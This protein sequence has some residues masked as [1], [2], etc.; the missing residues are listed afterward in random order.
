MPSQHRLTMGN[1]TVHRSWSPPVLAIMLLLFACFPSACTSST[2]PGQSGLSSAPTVPPPTRDQTGTG[3]VTV[4]GMAVPDVWAALSFRRDGVV[5]SILVE[6]GQRVTTGQV[7]IRLN[8]DNLKLAVAQAE[9]TLATAQAELAQL[10]APTKQVAQTGAALAT[11]QAKL[12]QLKAPTRQVAQTEAALATA[13]ARLAQLKAPPRQED[14]AV[15][16]A[17]VD[18]AKAN[19]VASQARLATTEA[20]GAA[21]EADLDASRADLTGFEAALS[22][23]Q[24]G[25]NQ[26]ELDLATLEIERAKN[27]LWAAQLTRDAVAGDPSTPE[28]RVKVAQATTGSADVAVRIAELE[29]EQLSAAPNADEVA[30]AQADVSAAKASVTGAEARLTQAQARLDEMHAE[31]DAS[32][33]S[34]EQAQ[35][36]LAYLLAGPTLEEIAVAEAGVKEAEV[37]YLLAGPTLEEIAVA[38]A[39][40][41]EAEVAYLL[42]GPTS[43]EIAVAEAEVKEAE[44]GLA[45]AQAG[46]RQAEL[47]A[48]FS[49]TVIELFVREGESVSA[50]QP[51]VVL[52]D[53]SRSHVESTNL[54]ELDVTKIEIG[55]PAE[56]TFDALPGQRLS[57]WVS[58]IGLRG[59]ATEEGTLYKV[60]IQLHEQMPEI[61]W[62]ILARVEVCP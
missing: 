19:L 54:D 21:A 22:A 57:G 16:Q 5:E 15:A 61:R 26:F 11:A 42:A 14:I 4:T 29:Y 46:L 43:E 10:K 18:Q 59:T 58:Y 41:K 44:G 28:Y 36:E 2:R 8:T 32:Q 48:P 7:L 33:A 38:E 53:L 35:A 47:L 12:A 40:V 39:E 30:K 25:A 9:A 17:V 60:I 1:R 3:T 51:V 49:G 55:D 24:A 52:A 20:A 6:E 23:V 27:E 13:Q 56:V 62:G 50:N 34:L 37:A 45:I 31:V